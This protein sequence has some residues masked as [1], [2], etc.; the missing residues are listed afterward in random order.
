MVSNTLQ[1]LE[2]DNS[3]IK[4][5]YR[6]GVAYLNLDRLDESEADLKMA[7]QIDPNGT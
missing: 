2:H 1:V 5:L 3:N 6:R 7:L 4:A